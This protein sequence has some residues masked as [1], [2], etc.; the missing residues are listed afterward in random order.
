MS[1]Y[2]VG[3]A[4]KQKVL[5]L[6]LVFVV[7]F[8]GA[9]SMLNLPVDA[10]PDVAPTQVK[11]ILK[12]SGMT[13]AEMETRVTIPIEQN[14]QSIPNQKV[15]RSLSKYGICDIT[16]DFKDDVD[17]SLFKKIETEGLKKGE[18]YGVEWAECFHY[19][20]PY[21]TKLETYIQKNATPL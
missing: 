7:L 8:F 6:L 17:E 18:K 16:I 1:E 9:S 3:F 19:I 13:P 12:A 5:V 11:L 14:M 20:G 4:L 15:V 21:P 10:Y 2:L